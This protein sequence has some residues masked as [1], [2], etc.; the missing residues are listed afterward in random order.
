VPPLV[1]VLAQV[2]APLVPEPESGPARVRLSA[3]QQLRP[4][5]HL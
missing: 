4:L 5:P 1:L 3:R 2:P